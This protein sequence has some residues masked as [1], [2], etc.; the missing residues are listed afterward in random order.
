MFSLGFVWILMCQTKIFLFSLICIKEVFFK[1]F[2]LCKG[3]ECLYDYT[4][5]YITLMNTAIE[6]ISN[7]LWRFLNP[8]QFIGIFTRAQ[9]ALIVIFSLKSTC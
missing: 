8:P 6:D 9:W 7:Y 4:T 3:M 1:V 2:L 5:G